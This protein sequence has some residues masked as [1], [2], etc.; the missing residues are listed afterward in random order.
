MLRNGFVEGIEQTEVHFVAIMRALLNELFKLGVSDE[1]VQFR[2]E[3]RWTN[4]L[5]AFTF[6]EKS[7]NI[8]KGCC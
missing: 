4:T 7:H 8:C 3:I 6:L 2:P 1:D 5:S